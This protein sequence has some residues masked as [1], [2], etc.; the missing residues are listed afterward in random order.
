ISG[1]GTWSHQFVPGIA[2]NLML[3][4]AGL[5]ATGVQGKRY[6]ALQFTGSASTAIDLMRTTHESVVLSAG[7]TVTQTPN[8]LTGTRQRRAQATTAL[9][10]TLA[11]LVMSVGADAAQT[12]PQDDLSAN[13]LFGTSVT[14]GYH[15][16]QAIAIS[17]E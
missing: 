2:G 8:I 13:R 14:V 3:G 11:R 4:L 1:L 7:G 6:Y 5:R 10:A 17:A 15:P 9:T 16:A 12:L